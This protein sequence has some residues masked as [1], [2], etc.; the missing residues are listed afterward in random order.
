VTVKNV[1]NILNLIS[2]FGPRAHCSRA[3]RAVLD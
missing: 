1:E 3:A 2:I